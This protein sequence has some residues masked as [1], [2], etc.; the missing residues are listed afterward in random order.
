MHLHVS[1][2]AVILPAFLVVIL[3]P[4]NVLAGNKKPVLAG[5]KPAQ[6]GQTS[7]TNARPQAVFIPNNKIQNL[8]PSGKQRKDIESIIA[9]LDSKC[10][11]ENARSC[12]DSEGN[13]RLDMQGRVNRDNIQCCNIQVQNYA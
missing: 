6:T 3:S 7:N 9:R 2:L 11:R 10:L 13:I 12:V 8:K 5:T 4:E 1:L